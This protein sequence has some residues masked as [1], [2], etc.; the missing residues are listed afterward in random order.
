MKRTTPFL[1]T[2]VA[3]LLFLVGCGLDVAPAD[4]APVVNGANN[5][6]ADPTILPTDEPTDTADAAAPD[7]GGNNMM[8]NNM[9]GNSMANDMADPA[10]SSG[11]ATVDMAALADLNDTQKAIAI[12][13][14]DAVAAAHLATYNGWHGDAYPQDDSGILWY[15]DLYA[16]ADDEWLGY[17]IVNIETGQIT[18]SFIPREL[19][20]EEYQEGQTA[21]EAFVLNDG[22]VLALLG[23]PA[24]WDRYV[25]YNRWDVKWEVYFSQGLDEWVAIVYRDEYGIYLEGI[26]DP[27][28]LSDEETAEMNRSQAIELA[29]S[30]EG[31]DQALNGVDNWST[32]VALQE[33]N[34]WVVTFATDE[35]TLF[36]ALV[37]IEQWLVLESGAE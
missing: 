35:R 14:A 28:A 23:D 33:G 19:T 9:A 37:D 32:Y 13:A 36:Y 7:M 20:T 17:G 2:L 21:V 34:V 4:E 1:F 8:G 15:V 10:D 27:S 11:G 12:L 30:A 6:A 25:Y 16:D 24:L 31:I 29:Y 22:E 18:E 5:A 3:V 26:H